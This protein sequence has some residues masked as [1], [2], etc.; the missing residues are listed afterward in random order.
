MG[1]D[2]AKP[3]VPDN[4]LFEVNKT[5]YFCKGVL[6]KRSQHKKIWEA[7]YIVINS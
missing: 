1:H 5:N 2:L 3:Y 7:R 4:T 6:F